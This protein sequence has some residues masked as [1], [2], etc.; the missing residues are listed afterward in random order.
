MSGYERDK[1]QDE[2]EVGGGFH[3]TRVG[4]LGGHVA[5]ALLRSID[6]QKKDI[7]IKRG[8]IQ[9]STIR[10]LFWFHQERS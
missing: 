2:G 7:S 4:L 1:R 10:E 5:P 6:M 3:G 9:G 8:T